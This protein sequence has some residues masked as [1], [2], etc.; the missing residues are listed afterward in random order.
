MC[1]DDDGSPAAAEQM[2]SSMN[3]MSRTASSV[4]GIVIV[5]GML[6]ARV[7]SAGADAWS[8]VEVR[9]GTAS[10]DAATNVSAINVHGKSTELDAR[11][12]VLE[13]PAGISLDRVEAT[14]PVKSLA[15]GM[16]VRDEHMRKLIFTNPDGTVPDVKFVSHDATCAPSGAKGQAACTVAGEL[17]IRGL[18]RPFTITLTVSRESGGGFR[19]AGDGI[20][21][22]SAYG[23]EQPSQFGVR[24]RDEVKL[25]LDF[26][27][28][29][30][31]VSTAR[32]GSTR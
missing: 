1:S 21:K 19:A 17:A 18:L 32:A 27:A 25:H 23:I 2:E 10:F 22:L 8:P 3:R 4:Y 15:T 30:T 13:G 31:G 9:G 26:T 20:V 6:A 29:P 16:G 24:T 5:S 14:L 28:H 11:A 7:A 12:S